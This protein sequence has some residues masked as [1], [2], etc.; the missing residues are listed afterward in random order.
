MLLIRNNGVTGDVLWGVERKDIADQLAASSAQQLVARIPGMATACNKAETHAALLRAGPPPFWPRSWIYWGHDA[1]NFARSVFRD[2]PNDAVF[3]SKPTLGSQGAGI[4]ITRGE[5][6]L[7]RQLWT[8]CIVQ[9]YVER[10]LLLGGFKFDFRVYV[11]VCPANEEQESARRLGSAF[12]CREGL[13]RFATQPYGIDSRRCKMD[14][15]LTNTSLAKLSDTF[16]RST[17]PADG[18]HGT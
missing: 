2:L 14:V 7:R 16:E 5:G 13:A 18:R 17:D 6:E 12:L 9:A 15:H 10:P 8:S 11:M 3:I 1:P 4:L